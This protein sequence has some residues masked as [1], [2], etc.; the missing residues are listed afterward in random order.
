MTLPLKIV[1]GTDTVE[2]QLAT[3]WQAVNQVER[4][5]RWEPVAFQI[6]ENAA[7]VIVFTDVRENT[8]CKWFTNAGAQVMG[9]ISEGKTERVVIRFRLQEKSAVS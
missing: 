5:C 3:I 2:S 4:H 7:T 8:V 9:C 1:V 6:V